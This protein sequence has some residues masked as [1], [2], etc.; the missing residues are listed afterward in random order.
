MVLILAVF[1]TAGPR[2]VVLILAIFWQRNPNM[3]YTFWRGFFLTAGPTRGIHF[4][5]TF[6]LTAGPQHLVLILDVFFHSGPK[7]VVL[8]LAGLF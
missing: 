4:S 3:W 6:F 8:I 2:H 1:F 5:G 7:H